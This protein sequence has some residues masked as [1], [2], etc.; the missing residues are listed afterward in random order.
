MNVMN[1][2]MMSSSGKGLRRLLYTLFCNYQREDN[3]NGDNRNYLGHSGPWVIVDH[4][5]NC[6]G[7]SGP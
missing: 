1:Q 4:N 7:H 6:L 5:R 2:Q 3:L